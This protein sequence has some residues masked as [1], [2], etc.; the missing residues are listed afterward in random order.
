MDGL[1]I[2]VALMSYYFMLLSTEF[3]HQ[4]SADDVNDIVPTGVNKLL[5]ILSTKCSLINFYE[6][7]I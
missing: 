3:L 5:K 7:Q 2:S 6:D 4:Y 1:C